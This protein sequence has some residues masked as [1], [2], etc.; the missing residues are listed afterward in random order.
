MFGSATGCQ[1]LTP[2]RFSFRVSFRFFIYNT[3]RSL[4]LTLQGYRY[5]MRHSKFFIHHGDA[6]QTRHLGGL[7]R[8]NDGSLYIFGGDLQTVEGRAT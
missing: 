2:N 1:I 5:S 3:P 8:G 7:G 4:K 6:Q